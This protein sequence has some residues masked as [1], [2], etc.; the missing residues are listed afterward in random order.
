MDMSASMDGMTVGQGKQE[1]K[2]LDP[3]ELDRYA[4]QLDIEGFGV[5][6]QERLK[7][8][9]VLVTRCGGLGGVVAYELAAAGIGRMVVAHGGQL[10]SSDM[11]RQLLMSDEMV[12]KSRMESIVR[13]LRQFNSRM[14]LIPYDVNVSGENVEE[15]VGQVDLVVDCAPLFEERYLLNREV[16]RRGI[17]MVECAVY[18]MEAVLTCILPGKTPCLRCLYP[19]FPGHRTGI[20][21]FWCGIRQSGIDGG[22]GGH[23][24][25]GWIRG[26]IDESDAAL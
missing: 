18:E 13:R 8:A 10:K 5:R 23:Q 26:T 15:L 19:E 11:N 16:V 17:P 9:S 24:D 2:S 1:W 3:G 12:G 25:I 4:W 21:G 14:E 20:S 7:N 6:G 22:H